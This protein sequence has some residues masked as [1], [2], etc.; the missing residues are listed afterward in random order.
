MLFVALL[1]RFRN[2]VP[3]ASSVEALGSI[4]VYWDE[5][6]RKPVYSIDWG[7]LSLGQAKSVTVYVRNEGNETVFL[8][9]V[10]LDWNPTYASQYLGFSWDIQKRKIEAGGVINVTQTLYAPIYTKGVS[11]FSFVIS[12]FGSKIGDFGSGTPPQCF[13]FDG[14]VDS[15]DL[16]LF[17]QCYKGT[18]P[19]EAMYLC[20]IGGGEPPQLY[21]SDGQVD[22]R[23][24]W[25]FL[26]CYKG[27]APHEAM[28]L[29][30]IGGGEPPQ[31]YKSDGQ[32]DSRDLWLFL[33]F[34]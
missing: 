21:K 32:V 27:T 18:A 19:H 29:C 11:S 3:N 26:Q 34:F 16:W 25:L 4:G 15:R 13:S 5:Y 8:T 28:Y 12:L 2:P 31:L 17:L 23:D 14:Q 22:S 1:L 7:N 30:D 9:E 33:P 10:A 20:D 24:L 6:C